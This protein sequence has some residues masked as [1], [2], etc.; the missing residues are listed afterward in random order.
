MLSPHV[1]NI[2]AEK[3]ASHIPSAAPVAPGVNG[4]GAPSDENPFRS[5]AEFGGVA[6]S[7]VLASTLMGYTFDDAISSRLRVPG[8]WGPVIGAVGGVV[9]TNA[10]AGLTY[11]PRAAAG[12]AL[13]GAAALVPTALAAFALKKST[14]DD[15]TVR[16]LALLAG[17]VVLYGV[18]RGITRR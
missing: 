4:Y 15:T 16:V 11:G 8:G 9:L 3:L 2:V 17:G 13:G 5:A 14:K 18:G 1:V 12:Y 10:L 6:S 7:V